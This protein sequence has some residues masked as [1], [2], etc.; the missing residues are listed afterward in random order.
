VFLPFLLE[1]HGE[2]GTLLLVVSLVF[3]RH[4]YLLDATRRGVAPPRCFEISFLSKV[5]TEKG[6]VLSRRVP[7]FSF[8][9]DSPLLVLQL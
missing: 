7:S 2:K 9:G 3:F 8:A 4:V 5:H 6:Y 1:V